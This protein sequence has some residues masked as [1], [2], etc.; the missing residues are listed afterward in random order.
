MATTRTYDPGQHVLTYNNVPITSFAK[1]SYITAKRNSDV[2]S[3]KVG[4]AGE[5]A[6]NRSRDATGTVK[7]SLMA[8]SPENDLLSAMLTNDEAGVPG[9]YGTLA[10]RD[11][12][13][14][15]KILST[16]AW[17][18]RW[19]DVEEADEMANRDWEFD[20]ADFQVFVGGNR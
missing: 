5:V 15:T 10:L 12:N 6:R 9:S 18:K 16:S 8:T 17:I 11:M 3:M 7:V 4:A 1:G 13:G 20:C 2:F 14:T 19:P